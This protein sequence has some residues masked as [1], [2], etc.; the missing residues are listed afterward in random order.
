MW[1][2]L[3]KHLNVAVDTI[4][5]SGISFSGNINDHTFSYAS[6]D[7]DLNN[8]LAFL[9]ASSTTVLAFVLDYLT[10]S[11]AYRTYALLLHHTEDALS[12]VGDDAR[13]MTGLASFFTATFLCSRTVTVW[14]VD[15]FA[16]LEFLDD[17]CIDLL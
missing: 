11:A 3:D 12:G 8:F 13:T 1:S 5:F 7:V 4:M 14:A 17:A 10:F 15:V 6:G 9:D 2:F 16:Y